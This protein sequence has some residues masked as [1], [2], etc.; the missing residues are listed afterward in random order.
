LLIVFHLDQSACFNFRFNLV[1]VQLQHDTGSS[2]IDL[3][4][5]RTQVRLVA[6]GESEHEYGPL[7]PA[8]DQD[9]AIP[10]RFS[11]ALARDTLLD[12]ATAKIGIDQ[13]GFGPMNGI[14]KRGIADLFL[15]RELGEPAVGVDAGASVLSNSATVHY[16]T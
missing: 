3:Q 4:L 12:E 2:A 16:H 15:C 11:S 1:L 6:L 7:A 9:R 13:A 5:S 14:S 8:E 10:S